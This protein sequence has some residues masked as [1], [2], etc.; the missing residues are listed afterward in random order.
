[1][2]DL[3][4]ETRRVREHVE[5]VERERQLRELEAEDEA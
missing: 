3:V 2:T 1:M 5:R 4:D